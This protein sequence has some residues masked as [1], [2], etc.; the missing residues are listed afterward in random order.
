MTKL[1]EVRS[2]SQITLEVL[3]TLHTTI[4]VISA[5]APLRC[6]EED[7]DAFWLALD[8][9]ISAVPSEEVLFLGADFNGHVGKERDD[10]GQ[11]HGG[12]GYGTRNSE[13]E[14][15]L[16]FASAHDLVLANTYYIKSDSHLV[17][18]ASGD[19]QTQVDY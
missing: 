18:Y 4:R 14:R 3:T 8:E 13:G 12:H 2:G 5:Y 16:D 1:P 19:R 9:Y 15:I 6:C 17:T 11:C 10:S 7:K